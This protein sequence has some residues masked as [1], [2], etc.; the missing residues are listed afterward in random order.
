MSG[1]FTQADLEKLANEL[2]EIMRMGTLDGPIKL[3]SRIDKK[4]SLGQC[5]PNYAR[6]TYKIKVLDPALVPSDVDNDVIDTCAHELAHAKFWWLTK[7]KLSKI[8]EEHHE[9]MINEHAALAAEVYRL[10]RKGRRK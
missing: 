3:V 5:K 6:G 4:G 1:K 2:R 9:F 8:E 7:K 10:R